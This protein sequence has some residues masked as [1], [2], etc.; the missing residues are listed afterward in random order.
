[1]FNFDIFV[2]PE[3]F[4][5]VAIF[6]AVFLPKLAAIFGKLR[7]TGAASVHG[8]LTSFVSSVIDDKFAVSKLSSNVPWLF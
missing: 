4:T 7:F 8:S 1:M 3:L 2:F 5:A 6:S